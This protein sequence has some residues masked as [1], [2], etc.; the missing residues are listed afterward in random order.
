MKFLNFQNCVQD[1]FFLFFSHSIDMCMMSGFD[2][3]NLVQYLYSTISVEGAKG[4]GDFRISDL[5]KNPHGT[6]I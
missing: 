5:V 2:Q 6:D 1:F 4:D 3:R